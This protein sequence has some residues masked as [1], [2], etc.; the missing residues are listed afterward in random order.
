MT[1]SQRRGLARIG[2]V[3]VLTLATVYVFQLAGL[4]WATRQ[5]RRS[6]AQ[7]RA[8]VAQEATQIAALEAAAR[9]AGS[10]AFVER[11]ARDTLKM[12]R[13]GD[14]VLVPVTAAPPAGPTPTPPPPD[15]PLEQ[16]WRWIQ[17]R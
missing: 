7:L 16:L 6:E 14:Q 12:A 2:A 4:A 15:G 17:R 3:V 9:D 5:A 8:E 11:Y 10:E 13:P 1:D